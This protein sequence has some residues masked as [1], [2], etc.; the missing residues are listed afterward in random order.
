MWT[1]EN[2]RDKLNKKPFNLTRKIEKKTWVIKLDN[3]V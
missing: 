2:P 1:F 3:L